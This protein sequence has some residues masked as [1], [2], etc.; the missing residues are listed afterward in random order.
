MVVYTNDFGCRWFCMPIND[1]YGPLNWGSVMKKIID[2]TINRTIKDL[3]WK[4][5][6]QLKIM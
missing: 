1:N 5:T 3:E 4:R 6:Y 2:F